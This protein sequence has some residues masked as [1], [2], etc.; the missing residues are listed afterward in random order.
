MEEPFSFLYEFL[1]FI[2]L[3]KRIKYCG[4]F[5]GDGG[6]IQTKPSFY[7]IF[8]EEVKFVVSSPD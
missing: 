7:E 1:F 6:N 4:L 3:N 5:G 8:P 2:S